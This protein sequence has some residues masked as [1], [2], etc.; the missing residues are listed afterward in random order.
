MKMSR[1]YL[2]L[3]SVKNAS[4][5]KMGRIGFSE[6]FVNNNQTT[7]VAQQNKRPEKLL[8]IICHDSTDCPPQD[9]ILNSFS[10]QIFRVGKPSFTPM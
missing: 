2:A 3:L 10:S 1:S 5:L 9:I 8:P 7:K 6:D 4:L